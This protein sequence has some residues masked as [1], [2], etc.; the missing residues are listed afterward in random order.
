MQEKTSLLKRFFMRLPTLLFIEVRHRKQTSFGGAIG[1]VDW[2]KQQ[3]LEK[4]AECF[5]QQH[6]QLREGPCRFDLIAF[7]G[8]R[9]EWIRGIF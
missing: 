3:R 9:I 1:S 8:E 6:P 7:E 2:H 4:T 5:L